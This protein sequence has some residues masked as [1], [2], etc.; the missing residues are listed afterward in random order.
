[1]K[2]DLHV[3]AKERSACGQSSEE[4]MIQA[5]LACGLDGLA[6]T[7]H[8]RLVSPARL[9]ELNRAYASFRVFCGIEI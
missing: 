9:E 3:H 4:E 6:F 2:T 7:D 5:A 8:H 1:M